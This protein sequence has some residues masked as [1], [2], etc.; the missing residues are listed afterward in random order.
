MWD[1]PVS[2]LLESSIANML[3]ICSPTVNLPRRGFQHV[4]NPLCERLVSNLLETRISNMLEMCFPGVVSNMLEILHV[5]QTRFQLVG[6][7]NFRHVGHLL[8]NGQFAKAR[9]P[10]CWKSFM[11]DRTVSNML[12]TAIS[13]MLEICFP[14]ANLPRRGFQHV[15]N[16]SCETGPFPTCWKRQFPKCWECVFRRLICQG[17]VSSMLEIVHERQ[18][19]F[20]LV[21]NANFQ[22]VGNLLS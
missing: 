15:G 16:L 12:E 2:N 14:K 4:G 13:N 20:Q 10:T 19:R 18:A 11:W 8:S 6:N 7:G 5:R 22:L 21:G 1:R 3:E 17:M 9:F